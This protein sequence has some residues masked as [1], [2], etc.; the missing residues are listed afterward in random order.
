MQI[1]WFTVATIAFAV[2]C[3]ALI[4]RRTTLAI[5]Q[6]TVGLFLLTTALIL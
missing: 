6:L 2:T 4:H 1:D 5:G 3:T